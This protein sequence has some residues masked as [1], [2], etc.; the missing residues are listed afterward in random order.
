M[1]KIEQI[2]SLNA[3]NLPKQINKFSFVINVKYNHPYESEIIINYCPG[4]NMT[5]YD[6]KY[7]TVKVIN[8]PNYE[9]SHE[10]NIF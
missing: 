10:V 3:Y 9:H 5:I 4:E 6:E 1:E 2:V 7:M 8:P